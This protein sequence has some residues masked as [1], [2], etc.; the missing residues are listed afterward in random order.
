MYINS[1]II[2]DII[3]VNNYYWLIVLSITGLRNLETLYLSSNDFKESNLIE[4]LGALPSLKTLDAS[5]S[6]FTHFGKGQWQFWCLKQYDIYLYIDGFIWSVPQGCLIRLALKKCS[7]M[8]LIS[9]QAFLGTLDPCLLLKSYPWAELTSI[10][11]YLPK[12]IK[13]SDLYTIPWFI[14]I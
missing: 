1:N 6:K 14:K 3:I 12:V 10:A 13:K 11:P 8:I 9:Q 5:E 4:S 7:S 2:N